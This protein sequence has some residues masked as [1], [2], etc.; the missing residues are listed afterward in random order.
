MMHDVQLTA[1]I[2]AQ[3]ATRDLLEA[4]RALRALAE[5]EN[6]DLRAALQ[7][8][9][10]TFAGA[11]YEEEVHKDQR[12][13]DRWTPQDWMDFFQR[14]APISQGWSDPATL[15]ER[16]GEVTQER[17]QAMAEISRLRSDVQTLRS[18]LASRVV[19]KDS[20]A[21]A[22]PPQA[23]A[24]EPPPD[25]NDGGQRASERPQ[26]QSQKQS[27]KAESKSRTSSSPIQVGGYPGFRWPKVPDR[28]PSAYSRYFDQK[29]WHRESLVLAFLARGLSMRLEV[30]EL[31]GLRAGIDPRSGS[32]RRM[33][34]RLIKR[35]ILEKELYEVDS[36]S[37]MMVRLTKRGKKAAR[38][39]GFTVVEGE[40]DRMLRLHGG[41]RQRTHAAAAVVF[42]YHARQRGWRVDV[43]PKVEPPAAPDVLIVNDSGAIYVEVERGRGNAAS[44]W[45]NLFDLQQHVA[46]C[47]I[48]PEGR[49]HLVREVKSLSIPGRATDIQSLIRE[50]DR[51]RLWVDTWK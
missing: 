39:S 14:V 3:G 21:L 26:R 7:L 50:N 19:S 33:F 4:E 36:A 37:V 10:Y 2:A 11:A 25:K 42:A 40:L 32:I 8:A 35:K 31:I 38:S 30:A 29:Q 44:K 6:R 41:E 17:D 1:A 15:A 47:A 27:R 48:T 24:E 18:E 49:A 23:P 45:R 9:A 13:L 51:G 34:D 46:L 22:P 12:I 28:P 16:L 43:M 20:P 5:E